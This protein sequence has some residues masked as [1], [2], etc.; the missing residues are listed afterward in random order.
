MAQYL[1]AILFRLESLRTCITLPW[2]AGNFRR[3]Q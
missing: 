3:A 2:V 1:V